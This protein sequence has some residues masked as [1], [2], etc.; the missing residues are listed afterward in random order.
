MTIMMLLLKSYSVH[1]NITLLQ[2]SDQRITNWSNY[3]GGYVH[4]VRDGHD[5][6]DVHNVQIDDQ[7]DTVLALGVYVGQNLLGK[8]AMNLCYE[9]ETGLVVAVVVVVWRE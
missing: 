5:V 2:T 4:G 3:S 7:I 9:V 6:H 1:N 8:R